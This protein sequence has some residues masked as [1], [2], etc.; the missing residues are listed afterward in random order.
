MVEAHPACPEVLVELGEEQAEHSSHG[1]L[2]WQRGEDTSASLST[3]WLFI[4]LLL[5]GN[6]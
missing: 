2:C 5:K 1:W 6:M 4:L 3:L